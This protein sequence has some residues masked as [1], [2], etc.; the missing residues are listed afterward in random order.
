MPKQEGQRGKTSASLPISL[1]DY[2][3][4]LSRLELAFL[5]LQPP[6]LNYLQKP[7][8]IK[9]DNIKIVAQ[10]LSGGEEGRGTTDLPIFFFCPFQNGKMLELF[11]FSKPILNSSRLL[12][13]ALLRDKDQVPAFLGSQDGACHQPLPK[14]WVQWKITSTLLCPISAPGLLP[15]FQNHEPVNNAIFFS[16]IHFFSPLSLKW[17]IIE[18]ENS[19]ATLHTWLKLK[20]LAAKIIPSPFWSLASRSRECQ[21]SF[22]CSQTALLLNMPFFLVLSR[23][24]SNQGRKKK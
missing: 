5:S 24:G 16:S 1:G 21:R 8:G 6:S 22:R 11:I 10:Q 7:T 19:A 4:L 14:V 12:T 23:K 20:T 9:R 17:F 3:C 13:Q 15:A 2:Q 18:E